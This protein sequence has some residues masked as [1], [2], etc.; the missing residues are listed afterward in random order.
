MVTET[1]KTLLSV[2]MVKEWWFQLVC[3]DGCDCDCDC[4]GGGSDDNGGGIRSS[5]GGASSLY[6]SFFE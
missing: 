1:K 6:T 4:G 2:L 5:G 3:V